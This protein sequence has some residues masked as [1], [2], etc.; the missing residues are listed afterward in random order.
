L[1][2]E[3]FTPNDLRMTIPVKDDRPFCG[4]TH[5]DMSQRFY[6]QNKKIKARLHAELTLGIIGPASLGKQ[7]QAGWHDI[8]RQSSSHPELDPD[9]SQGWSRQL[10]DKDFPGQCQVKLNYATAFPPLY[11]YESY[12]IESGTEAGLNAGS[13]YGNLEI[14]LQFRAGKLTRKMN[15][16]QLTGNKSG[17]ESYVFGQTKVLVNG[18]N[19][20]LNG[21][22]STEVEL[23]RVTLQHELGYGLRFPHPWP[24]L[25]LSISLW[26]RETAQSS[27]KPFH[28][29]HVDYR[30]KLQNRSTGFDHGFG[31]LRVTWQW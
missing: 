19:A 2:Q 10:G 9:P 13:L 16:V 23:A 11:E 20:V 6:W 1:G 14:G 21:G 4:W 12:R 7:V 31:T 26:S 27:R 5:L 8:R 28:N 30:P 29:D 17:W 3:I 24:E 15:Q 22:P 18:W 25:G